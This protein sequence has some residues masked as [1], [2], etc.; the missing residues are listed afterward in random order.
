MPVWRTQPVSR[1]PQLT[2]TDWRV[3]QLHDG[4]RHLVGYCIENREGR[5][6]SVVRK[7]DAAA[8]ALETGTGRVYRLSGPPGRSADADYV[9]RTWLEA[10]QLTHA[11]DV[12]GEV[13][14]A[15]LS[16]GGRSG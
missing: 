1:Q 5:V 13:Y 10:N 2:L 3:M 9:W 7:F 4:D 15:I 6:S 14:D 11:E 8:R 12:S 16:A